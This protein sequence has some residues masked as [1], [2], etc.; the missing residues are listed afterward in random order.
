MRVGKISTLF[1]CQVSFCVDVQFFFL[2]FML[3]FTRVRPQAPHE[4]QIRK[5]KLI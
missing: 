2:K 3:N 5:K 4:V 1:V